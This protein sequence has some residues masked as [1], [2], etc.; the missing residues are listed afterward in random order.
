[1]I[2]LSFPPL[3]PQIKTLVPFFQ[4]LGWGVFSV[5]FL[6]LSIPEPS[7][8]SHPLITLPLL[9]Y[10]IFSPLTCLSLTHPKSLTFDS[11]SSSSFCPIATTLFSF[12]PFERVVYQ[13]F[14][15]FPM[16]SV[17]LNQMSHFTILT[18]FPCCSNT[19]DHIFLLETL[20]NFSPSWTLL[21]LHFFFP[22]LLSGLFFLN[23]LLTCRDPRIPTPPYSS[24]S[25]SD[26]RTSPWETSLILMVTISTR[27][28]IILESLSEPRPLPWTSQS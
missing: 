23:L 18:R 7:P 28:W 12:K 20:S 19:V 6:C 21:I 13:L 10:W 16:T 15:N 22:S 11:R 26:Y 27:M 14:P 4:L 1:M 8:F 2:F 5:T 25:S 9:T 3:N 17:P 24:Y